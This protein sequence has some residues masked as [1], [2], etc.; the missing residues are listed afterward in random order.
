MSTLDYFFNFEKKNERKRQG[1]QWRRVWTLIRTNG[2]PL[3]G[4]Q[5]APLEHFFRAGDSFPE[6]S[7]SFNKSSRL[8]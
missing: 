7:T 4:F 2:R 8:I 3:L 5:M 6:K 1:G